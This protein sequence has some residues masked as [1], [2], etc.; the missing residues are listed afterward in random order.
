MTDGRRAALLATLVV[1]GLSAVALVARFP[2]QPL[3]FAWT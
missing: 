1:V 2:S 3:I